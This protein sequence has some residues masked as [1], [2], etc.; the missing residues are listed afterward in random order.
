MAAAPGGDIAL[1]HIP[2]GLYMP[3]VYRLHDFILRSAG[4]QKF[5]HDSLLWSLLITR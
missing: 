4:F 5:L 1:F 3:T 2:H